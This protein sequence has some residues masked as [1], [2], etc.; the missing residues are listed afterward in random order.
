MDNLLVHHA[1]VIQDVIESVGAKVV[2]LPA[3][4]H[5]LSPIELYWSKRGSVFAYP[6][7]SNPPSS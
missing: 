4:S 1:Q 5:D 6:K 3:Y 2:F 7:S